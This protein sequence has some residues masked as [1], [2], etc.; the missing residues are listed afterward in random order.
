MELFYDICKNEYTHKENHLISVFFVVCICLY[1]ITHRI[2]LA[3][4]DQ[5]CM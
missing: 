2:L 5:V 3:M 4:P 1:K